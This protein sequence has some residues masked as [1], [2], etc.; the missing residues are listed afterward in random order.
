MN[1]DSAD[2][3]QPAYAAQRRNAYL[4]ISAASLMEI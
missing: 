1:M 4:P 2:L 3:P